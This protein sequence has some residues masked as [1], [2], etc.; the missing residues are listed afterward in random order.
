MKKRILIVLT[1][2]LLVFCLLFA[3]CDPSQQVNKD[4]LLKTYKDSIAQEMKGSFDFLWKEAQTDPTH[5]CYG[6]V[7]DRYSDKQ[8][9]SIASVGFALSGLIVGAEEGYV[10]REQAE[11]RA[12]GTLQTILRLQG[13]SSVAWNGFLAHFINLKTGKRSGNCEIS[14]IDTAILVCGALS[15]GE[16]FGGEV[17]QKALEV[18]SNV[19]WKAFEMTKKGKLYFSMAYDINKKK[20]SDGCWDWYAEQLML[21]VLAAGSPVEEYRTTKQSYYDFTR[22]TGSWGGKKFIYSYFGSIFTYQFSHAWINFNGIVDENGT[23]W[24]Q[25]SVDASLADY[26]Y[27][28][29]NIIGSKTFQEGGWGLTACDTHDGYSGKLGTPPRGW[30]PDSSYSRIEGTVAPCGAIGSVVFTPAQSLQAMKYYQDSVRLLNNTSLYGLSDSYNLDH[31]DVQTDYIGIDK[32]ISLLMLSNFKDGFIWQ[33]TMQSPYV[34]NGLN[35]LGFTA[36]GN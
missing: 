6:L 5:P 4:K 16:Y 21:Y 15:A 3:A 26:N 10:T 14:S 20:L 36:A 9:A 30:Q 29:D 28:K 31:N 12:L 27:C 33:Y 34:Q 11:Q 25:N 18:Y 22:E 8:T 35:V 7:Q 17:Q 24:W 2:I 23:D 13:D 19:N 1:A 32:G